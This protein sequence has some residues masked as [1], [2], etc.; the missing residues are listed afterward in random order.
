MLEVGAGTG[1][2]A[3]LVREKGGTIVATDPEPGTHHPD[4][5]FTY[6]EV[7]EME[8][9]RAVTDLVDDVALMICWPD[10]GKQWPLAAV[11]TY[12]LGNSTNRTVIYVGEGR[13]G[14]TGSDEFHWELYEHWTLSNVVYL[15]NYF[16]INDRLEVWRR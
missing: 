4:T 9:E 16:G 2:W 15:P 10:H 8:A 11:E 7:V 3:S 6:T 14:C 5:G 12:R 13:G 1:Y